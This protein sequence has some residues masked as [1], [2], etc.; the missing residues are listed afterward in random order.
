MERKDEIVTI[1]LEKYEDMKS[2]LETLRKEV[3]KK[4]IIKY[5]L[6][7]IYGYI[8]LAFMFLTF[9]FLLK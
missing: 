6:H 7:P 1:S 9:A 3:Q 4:T 2:E 8:F 5:R